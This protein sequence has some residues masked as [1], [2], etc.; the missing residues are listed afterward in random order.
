MSVASKLGGCAAVQLLK[1]SSSRERVMQ[2]VTGAKKR[3]LQKVP[4]A[5]CKT[6]ANDKAPWWDP[7]RP[8]P[9]KQQ[10]QGTGGMLGL[11]A[12]G[13]GGFLGMKHVTE[14]LQENLLQTGKRVL[15]DPLMEMVKREGA[16]DPKLKLDFAPTRLTDFVRS[17][18]PQVTMQNLP[19]ATN[20]RKM[21]GMLGHKPLRMPMVAGAAGIAGLLGM[22]AGSSLGGAMGGGNVGSF[23]GL[24]K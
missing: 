12:G 17:K 18:L 5:A 23:T 13:A 2:L 10:L 14:P 21:V 4:E 8:D 1:Q 9:A 15:S 20:L 22:Q 16:A 3:P 6:A 7:A 19:Q 24:P 11:G